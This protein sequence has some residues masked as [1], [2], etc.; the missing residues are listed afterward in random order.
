MYLNIR[1]ENN[2]F[3]KKKKSKNAFSKH[4]EIINTKLYKIPYLTNTY[5]LIHL[6]KKIF[7]DI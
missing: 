6:F 5:L 2:N 7:Y 1:Y 4:F 3:L